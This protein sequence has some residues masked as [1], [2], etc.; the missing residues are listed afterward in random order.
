MGKHP[1]Y[2]LPDNWDKAETV[3]SDS[4]QAYLSEAELAQLI[5]IGERIATALESISFKM[6]TPREPHDY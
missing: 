4:T 5:S 3:P 6:E 2:T 1:D